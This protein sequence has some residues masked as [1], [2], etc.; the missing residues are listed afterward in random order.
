MVFSTSTVLGTMK[1][2][3]LKKVRWS[4]RHCVFKMVLF[5]PTWKSIEDSSYKVER[6]GVENGDIGSL[7]TEKQKRT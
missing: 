1:K 4:Q 6:Q 7:E 5:G 2:S 3:L